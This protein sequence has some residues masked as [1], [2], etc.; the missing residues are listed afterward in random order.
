MLLVAGVASDRGLVRETNEDSYLVRTGLYA[1]CDGMGGA[2]GGEVASQMACETLLEL[3]LAE[4]DEEKLRDAIAAANLAIVG[5]SLSEAE[6]AGMGTT[7]TV[8]VAR[9]EGLL[10]GHVGDSRA[11]LLHDGRLR[12]LTADH[13][14]VGE[15]LR[16]GEIT[17]AEAAIHPHRSIITRALGTDM[18]VEPDLFYVPFAP[19]DRLLLCSDGL[20]GMVSDEKIAEILGGSE[21]PQAVAEALVQAALAA[22]G[23]DNVTVVVVEGREG[24]A[25]GEA[26]TS[27]GAEA[28]E[29]AG[30]TAGGSTA[31]SREADTVLLGPLDRGLQR[32]RTA[33][34]GGWEA[35]SRRPLMAWQRLRGG[36]TGGRSESGPEVT[37]SHQ[38]RPLR[39]AF[40]R[41]RVI[42][43]LIVIII[44]AALVGG[45]V[46][47]NSS[48]YYVGTYE[49]MVA[50]Y[51]GLPG[52]V[53]GIELS[54]VV[55]IGEVSYESLAPYLRERVD[56]H[57]LLSKEEGRAF[58]KTLGTLR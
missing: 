15:M 54:S 18:I 10:I 43:A 8:A 2:R 1:V 22:G 55:E 44:V 31:A 46:A 50:L 24:G 27:S 6:L 13:S 37:R 49:G 14:W 38:G 32:Q 57:D 7:L 29:E 9:E 40:T 51:Q 30:S 48:V 20:S 33:A 4:V 52:S 35:R 26:E 42:V 23:D 36:A 34:Q 16:R 25:T 58:L 19:G 12:Q 21:G 39:S 17:Q 3:D 5:R 56:A 47:F 28:A 45:F 11:Y 53:L 41:R